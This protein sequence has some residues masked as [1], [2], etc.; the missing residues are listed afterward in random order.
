M[1]ETAS[2]FGARADTMPPSAVRSECTPGQGVPE[3]AGRGRRGE[4]RHEAAC[5]GQVG[6][7]VG[8]GDA[9]VGGPELDEPG[10]PKGEV[11]PLYKVEARH[12][13]SP[14]LVGADARG[15]RPRRRAL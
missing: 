15:G 10:E 1:V 12:A 6:V 14:V 9:R 4:G 5:G 7:T 2:I 3:A 13:P 8:G 11:G